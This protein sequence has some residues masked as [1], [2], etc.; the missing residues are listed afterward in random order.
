[1]VLSFPLRLAPKTFFPREQ[2][3]S[4]VL[5][6]PVSHS[7]PLFYDAPTRPA[8]TIVVPGLYS[9][10]S[11]QRASFSTQCHFFLQFLFFFRS[12]PSSPTGQLKYV[13]H[14]PPST[15]N[16]LFP[17]P[18]L[19]PNGIPPH[20]PPRRLWSCFP[21]AWLKGPTFCD[22]LEFLPTPAFF[23]DASP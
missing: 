18:A 9:P 22:R 6:P 23:F 5:P 8:F 13:P 12:V 21:Q 20:P 17:P 7:W 1:L 15:M 19:F 3:F 14:L 16:G 11:F 10:T 4:K 2:S